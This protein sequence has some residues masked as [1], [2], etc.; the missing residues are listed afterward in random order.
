MGPFDNNFLHGLHVNDHLFIS[1]DIEIV[2]L[3]DN[4]Y[5]NIYILAI[6]SVMLSHCP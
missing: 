6:L 5:L 1:Y 4:D 3:W 2:F